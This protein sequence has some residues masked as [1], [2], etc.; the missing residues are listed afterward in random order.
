M[1]HLYVMV[2]THSN[3]T[4]SDSANRLDSSLEIAHMEMET[5]HSRGKGF[6]EVTGVGS[7]LLEGTEVAPVVAV[8][9]V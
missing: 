5:S 6:T 2:L 7:E 4:I 8:G 9:I 3:S 1:F